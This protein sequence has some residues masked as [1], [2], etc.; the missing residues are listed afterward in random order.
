MATIVL[1]A[2]GLAAGQAIGGSILGLSTAVLGRAIGATIGRVIDQKLLGQNSDPVERGKVDRFRL[3]GASEGAPVAHLHGRARVAGQVIWATRFK[4]SVTTTGGGKGGPP[5]PKV[6][7]YSYSVSLAIALCRGEISGVGRVWADGQ[8]MAWDDLDMRV[9][10]GT[11]AQMPD[12]RIE[13]VEGAGQAPAY[14]GTAYVV[15][16]DL[17]LGQFGNRVPQL[18]FEVFRPAPED[19]AGVE[20]DPA[21]AVQAVA[22]IPGTG[23]YALATTPVHFKLG[24]GVSR[25]ANVTSPTGRPDLLVSLNGLEAELPNC[26]A[27]SLVVSWFGSDLRCGL[28]AVQPKVEQKEQD[29]EGMAWRV[30]GIARDAAGLVPQDAQSRPVYGG[31]PADAAVIEAIGALRAAGQAVTFYPFI[32]MEQMAG[33]GLAD[34]WTGAADQP[35]LPWRGRITLS[36]APGQAGSPDRS[37]A[38][39]AEVAAF[40]GAA[41]P[42]DFSAD[43]GGVAYSGPDEFSFRRF[44]LHYAHLC[45]AAGGVEAFCIGSEMRGLTQIRGVEGFPAVDALRLLAAEVRAILGP[46]CKIG[47]AAD[48]SEYFGYHPQDGSGDVYFHLDPL[49]GDANIDFVG[50]DNYMPLSDW[51]DGA[52]HADAHWGSIY[53]LDYLRANIA[54]G[55]GYDWYYPHEEARAYQKRAPITDGDWDEPWVWRYKD[56]KGWWSN[57][58]YERV[59]GL[60]GQVLDGGAAPAGWGA[61]NGAVVA[62]SGAGPQHGAFRAPARVT[63]T[64]GDADAAAVSAGLEAAP[65]VLHEIAVYYAAGDAQTVRIVLPF[66][67]A[68]SGAD[69]VEVAGAPGALS[70]VRGGAHGVSG[71]DNADLGGGVFECRFSVVWADDDADCPLRVGPGDG[72][73]GRHM[74]LL[75]AHV[76]SPTQ[77]ASAWVPGSKPFWFTEYGCAAIDKGANQPNK[78]LD[79]K[80][81]ESALPH[82]STGRRDDFMQMQ[83]LRAITSHYADPA[84]NPVSDA[85]GGP[86]VDMARAHVWAWDARPYPF[87]PGREDVWS[88]GGNYFR[89]HWLNGRASARS[90]AGIAA[91]LCRDSG[92][93]ACDA[94]RLYGLTR[95]YVATGAGSGR[96]ALQPLMLAYGFDTV[97]RGG[98]I[99]FQS[100]DGIAGARIDAERLA[101]SPE[102]E[103]DIVMARAPEADMAGR[104]RLSFIEADGDYETRAEEAVFP[105]EATRSV[106][107]SELPLVLSRIEAR[108]IVERWLAETRVARDTVR[109]SLP[110]SRAGI[111]AGDVVRL[112]AGGDFRIDRVE[113]GAFQICDAQRVE[114]ELYE[115]SDA[116]EVAVRPR[117]FVPPLPVWPVLM[118]LPLLRGDEVPHAPHVAAAARPWPGSVAVYHAP[119]DDGYAL[120]TVLAGA[121][122]MGETLTALPAAA[123][124]VIDQGAPLRVRLVSGTLASASLARV[125]GGANAAAIGDGSTGNW[126]VFQFTGAALVGDRTW[127]LTGRLRG[128]A[129]TDGV[130]PDIWP[131]GSVFVLLNGVPQQ[132][133]LALPDR[134][135]A[136]HYRI[137]PAQR[138]YDDPSYTH[139]V[140]AV[141]GIG[142]RPYAPVHLRCARGSSGDGDGDGGGG[143]DLVTWVRRTRIDGDSWQSPEVPLGEQ[144]ERYLVRVV[145]GGSVRRQETAVEARFAYSAAMRA[146]D[147][148]SGTYFIDV[149]QVSARF[150]PGPFRRIEING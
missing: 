43:A 20:P 54:G 85:Y 80:S 19:L 83:Y 10:H 11:E 2:A 17:D 30:S 128:Q 32:L 21:R 129:G 135:L 18:N 95:G 70:L 76:F 24:K 97:E 127:E 81:S 34:P 88:D 87:F 138:G 71:V 146:A 27:T 69:P 65:E 7:D 36:A 122:V 40:F 123:P 113:T 94:R 98:A 46:D 41:Q 23:E 6:K 125:L 100:R 52:D 142:L 45:A 39:E 33:N 22:M 149:A 74:V 58:H 66:D 133:G 35:A 101:V 112:P 108:G 144:D 120:N 140:E 109:F 124:G 84:N 62:A 48:W 50:I 126:E 116:V 118:D 57:A 111:G 49:W 134:G 106:S 67:G 12:P 105:D 92:I 114:P 61:V 5:K 37:A 103:A 110:P 4:E 136:R 16:E 99:V 68:A 9:Y 3:T 60:R 130:M 29:G 79:P 73:P 72:A 78:F 89:G 51:R 63:D 1:S 75:G 119:G 13:A 141:D 96:A 44:I 107:A 132:I 56:L 117:P 77:S 115:P 47:Y 93:A 139:L 53:N 104:I 42:G 15:L 26:R 25:P 86:M 31:T 8:E 145:Q 55:E 121:S 102:A 147:G 64:A 14:R 150:G 90:L 148:V 28:C 91:E 131:E 38:A 143:T 59:G 137:G 82:F